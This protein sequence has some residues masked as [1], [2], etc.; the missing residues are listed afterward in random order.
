MRTMCSTIV[1]W[2]LTSSRTEIVCTGQ[3]TSTPRLWWILLCTWRGSLRA[4]PRVAL[5]LCNGTWPDCLGGQSPHKAVL[6]AVVVVW[7]Q[8]C[9]R[10]ERPVSDPVRCGSELLWP[11]GWCCEW[12][13][14]C[15]AYQRTACVGRLFSRCAV[16][17]PVCLCLIAGGSRP[18][19]P[20]WSIGWTT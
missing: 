3:E 2:S 9:R 5:S 4:Q 15:E 12:P 17:V 18:K 8:H 11:S 6:P 16:G 7:L 20:A 14:R 10:I 13:A 19:F 1:D